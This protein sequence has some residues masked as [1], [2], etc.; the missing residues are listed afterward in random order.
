MSE[1]E[2]KLKGMKSVLNEI[3]A[4]IGEIDPTNKDSRELQEQ[5]LDFQGVE[6]EGNEFA[7]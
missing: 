2:E 3:S 6:W 5:N 7:E 1:Y 4:D